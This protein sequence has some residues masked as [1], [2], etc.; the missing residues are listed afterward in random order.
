MARSHTRTLDR[1]RLEDLEHTAH[2]R[3][4]SSALS[5][6]KHFTPAFPRNQASDYCVRMISEVSISRIHDIK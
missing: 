5:D 2:R 4:E 3:S 1:G 6:I